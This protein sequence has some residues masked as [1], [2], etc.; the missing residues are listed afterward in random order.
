MFRIVRAYQ[1]DP[2][3]RLD[4]HQEIHIA[5]WRSFQGFEGRCSLKTWIYRVAQNTAAS[6]II[7][8][9]R[10]NAKA[11]LSLEDVETT[12]DQLDHQ[13]GLEDRLAL[14]RLF[15]LIHRLRALDRQL[16]LLY[17]EGLDLSL[18]PY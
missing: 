10:T 17:L 15:H 13:R 3:K 9:H 4:L 8:Q 1:S 12:A 6:H 2:D 7:R 5:L 11:L 14:D 18:F 16:M